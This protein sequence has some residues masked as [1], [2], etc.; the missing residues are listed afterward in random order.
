MLTGVGGRRTCHRCALL[1]APV[2]DGPRADG[3]TSE[4]RQDRRV[5]G[6]GF[7]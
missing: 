3:F 1:T 6:R 2:A 4:P 7:I 5:P